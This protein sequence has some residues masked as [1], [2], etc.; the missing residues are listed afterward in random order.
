MNNGNA[1]GVNHGNAIGNVEKIEQLKLDAENVTIDPEQGIGSVSLD[2][3]I[4]FSPQIVLPENPDAAGVAISQLFKEI[5][6]LISD[7]PEAKISFPVDLAKR[8]EQH[9]AEVESK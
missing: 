4:T 1:I 8:I 6:G 3:S 2:N 9:S 7:Q 5:R